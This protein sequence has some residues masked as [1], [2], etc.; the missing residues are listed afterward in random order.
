MGCLT[1]HPYFLMETI[2][3]LARGAIA[4]PPDQ[5][6]TLAQRI[7]ASVEPDGALGTA[8]AWVAEILERGRLLH[9]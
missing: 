1:C 7:L 4:L 9:G 5:R 8:G 6:F 3:D 2:D